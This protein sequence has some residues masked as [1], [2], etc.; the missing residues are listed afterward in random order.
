MSLMLRKGP[1]PLRSTPTTAPLEG[2]ISKQQSHIDELVA[3]TRS[4]EY[5]NVKLEEKLA[6]ERDRSLEALAAERERNKDT[7]SRIQELWAAERVEWSDGCDALQTAHRVAHLHTS[8]EL[9]KERMA[10]LREKENVRKERLA[11]AQRDY[12]LLLFQAGERSLEKQIH[13]LEEE[14]EDCRAEQEE[15]RRAWGAQMGA[16]EKKLATQLRDATSESAQAV[17]DKTKAEVR[18]PSHWTLINCRLTKLASTLR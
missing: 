18:Y 4:L 12:K 15:Q 10:V 1:T 11:K 2:M 5:A 14:L 13:E 7:M 17:K 9:D 16:R 3:K 6:A 8:C